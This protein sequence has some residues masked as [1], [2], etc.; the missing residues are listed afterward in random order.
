MNRPK[1]LKD[2]QAHLSN[3]KM[4]VS[5]WPD[6]DRESEKRV[7]R[8]ISTCLEMMEHWD[9]N[10]I[11]F[12]DLVGDLVPPLRQRWLSDNDRIL[13]EVPEAFLKL[14]S[15]ASPASGLSDLLWV[16]AAEVTAIMHNCGSSGPDGALYVPYIQSYAKPGKF[17]IVFDLNE[18]SN[19]SSAIAGTTV[20][21]HSDVNS[22]LLKPVALNIEGT[23]ECSS[24][25][26]QRGKL[27]ALVDYVTN[28][29]EGED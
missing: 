29:N 5:T 7:R 28:V 9:T 24:I 11:K 16:I 22:P 10:F 17:A 21:G 15:S 13:G 1:D 8:Q 19:H 20:K 14:C 26:N 3:N 4:F 23:S 18:E 25:A 27:V 12:N 6:G 2:L